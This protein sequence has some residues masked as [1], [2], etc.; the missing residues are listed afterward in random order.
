MTIQIDPITGE[1]I[2]PVETPKQTIQIDPLT[3][4]R[5][6]S[7]TPKVENNININKLTGQVEQ[8][9]I[10]TDTLGG[11]VKGTGIPA[12]AKVAQYGAS[13]I[14]VINQVI[15]N[16]YKGLTA[17]EQIA[18]IAPAAIPFMGP[19]AMIAGAIGGG[20][21]GATG[22]DK[23]I[24]KTVADIN[25]NLDKFAEGGTNQAVLAGAIKSLMDIAPA[26]LTIAFG[27]KPSRIEKLKGVVGRETIEAGPQQLTADIYNTI[28]RLNDIAGK[29][30][31]SVKTF[32][33]QNPLSIQAPK[34][35]NMGKEAAMSIREIYKQSKGQLSD[36][37]RSTF[38]QFISEA[39]ALGS[40]GTP[41]E[42]WLKLN[43]LRQRFGK[44]ELEKLKANVST[45]GTDAIY[46]SFKDVLEK[47]VPES[48]K[49][50]LS[51]ANNVFSDTIRLK[52]AFKVT[53]EFGDVREK[54]DL[55]TQPN[56]VKALNK[57]GSYEVKAKILGEIYDGAF[58]TA[59]E[60]DP[61]KLRGVLKKLDKNGIASN[62]LG[63]EFKT[64]EQMAGTANNFQKAW[65]G[66]MNTA[67]FKPFQPFTKAGQFTETLTGQ[68]FRLGVPTG[69]TAGQQISQEKRSEILK[70]KNKKSSLKSLEERKK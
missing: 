66:L 53:A 35:V 20:V 44:M 55:S 56:F 28:D 1:R 9:N 23:V 43:Q 25:V 65:S 37:A 15:P 67:F 68:G 70:F 60:F 32:I 31:G 47:Y 13:Q 3:G 22:I 42:Q 58:N 26:A 64:L 38:E 46:G 30:I 21:L 59:G 2:Q 27:R 54:I 48:Q 36:N 40:K 50:I 52:K 57:Y 62:V 10:G 29:Q 41:A 51:E 34:G 69:V 4:E 11:M 24:G 63:N 49:G 12:L 14:P 17:G 18:E 39:E 7:A 16:P 6:G 33:E 19:T 8:R 5:T 61:V 45:E